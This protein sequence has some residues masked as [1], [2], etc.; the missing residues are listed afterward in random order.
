MNVKRT[1]KF[2]HYISL[3][4]FGNVSAACNQC[5]TSPLTNLKQNGFLNQEDIVYYTNILTR[6]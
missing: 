4:V 2:S 5:S 1:L 6:V 3:S